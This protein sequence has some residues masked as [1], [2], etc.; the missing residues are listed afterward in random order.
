M[1]EM[2]LPG[3]Y[4][5]EIDAGPRS[6][7]P[8]QT[9]I[10]GML[11]ASPKGPTD[12]IVMCSSYADVERVFGKLVAGNDIAEKANV[13]FAAGASQINITR[14]TKG[15]PVKSTA[16]LVDGSAV[17]CV[18]LTA[19]YYGV[20]GDSISAVVTASASGGHVDVAITDTYSNMTE[21]Y[22]AMNMLEDSPNY[23]VN[24]ITAKSEIVDAIGLTE[25]N[26]AAATTALTGG[27]D[28]DT[29]DAA[30]IIG[31]T[32]GPTG[33]KLLETDESISILL[34]ATGSDTAVWTEMIAQAERAKNRIAI[35]NLA[36]G[37]TPSQA[38]SAISTFDSARFATT[39]PYVKVFDFVTGGT[40]E[41][42]G[43]ASLAGI[44][45]GLPA[46]RSPS[47]SV[48]NGIVGVARVLS[49]SEKEAL[50]QGR[51]IPIA[52]VLGQ[53]IRLIGGISGSS[54][55]KWAQLCKR[56]MLDKIQKSVKSAMSWAISLPNTPTLRDNV[57]TSINDFI[58]RLINNGEI[59]NTSSAI[60]NS[61][62]NTPASIAAGYLIVDVA[63]EFLYPA[64][65]IVIRYQEKMGEGA[66][67]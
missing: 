59:G 61:T 49:Q 48:V 54:D 5:Q 7:S 52:A 64:D 58:K 13:A 30:A 62:N 27:D 56:R 67:T 26:P 65:K 21:T 17:G 11:G 29:V 45:S 51:I 4:T 2:I 46:Y 31:E 28:G 53:G 3:I 63:I 50:Y 41:I 23:L 47:N 42:P 60:C 32:D 37:L 18:T 36:S 8:L 24:A 14:V 16:T 55:P 35:L 40:K 43:S 19:K 15:T 57:A 6:I 22:P 25:V 20:Y 1:S 10:I 34:C 9:G 44:L 33:L 38:V 66:T 12:E 39:F